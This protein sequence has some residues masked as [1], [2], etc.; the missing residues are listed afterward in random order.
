MKFVVLTLLLIV[1]T[2]SLSYAEEVFVGVGYGGRRI[3]SSDGQQWEISAQWAEG[4][5]DDSNNLMSLVFANGKFVATGGGGGGKTAGGHVLVST[6]GVNWKETWA[7]PNRV[8]PVVFDGQQLLLAGGP[9]RT[10]YV[11][12]DAETW[13]PAATLEDRRCTHFRHGVYGN[14]T[15][16]I[17][18]N[19]GGS[20]ECW[21][22]TTKDGQTIDHIEFGIKSIRGMEYANGVFVVVGEQTR[23]VS[24]D[25]KTWKPTGLA[26]E[27]KLSWLIHDGKAFYAGGWPNVYRSVDGES[28]EKVEMRFRGNPKWTDGTRIITTSWPGKM[29]FSPDFGKTWTAG[30][31]LTPNG[32][33]KIVRGEV[34]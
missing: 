32:I 30:N 16:V 14:G 33:N 9:G 12:E 34:K 17:T 4:G 20:S 28:W 2:T 13:R 8:N 7:A 15:F 18:G 23:L 25:G 1:G 31:P 11:S 26:A 29:F 24:T 3:V 5:R 27:E 10:I 6:D 21:I 19:R 22:A